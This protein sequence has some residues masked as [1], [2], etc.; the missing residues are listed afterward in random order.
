VGRQLHRILDVTIVY[1]DG[2]K[3]FWEFACGK[4]ERIHVQVDQIPVTDHL[5]GD[6]VADRTF[7]RQFQAWLND[8]WIKKD[9]RIAAVLAT[10]QNASG[11]AKSHC[12]PP[13]DRC[14]EELLSNPRKAAQSAP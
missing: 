13:E 7:K 9:Q 10:A 6:Y 1:P 12:D 2:P 8:L 14:R 5:I 4:I 3:S 11:T